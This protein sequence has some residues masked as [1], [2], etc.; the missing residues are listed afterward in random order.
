MASVVTKLDLSARAPHPSDSQRLA[1][2]RYIPEMKTFNRQFRKKPAAASERLK[3]FLG[4]FRA[5]TMPAAAPQETPQRLLSEPE[6][7]PI[8]TSGDPQ[9]ALEEVESERFFEIVTPVD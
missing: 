5:Q 4:K 6:E 2:V 9:Q 1:K 3:Q 8:Q 7:A